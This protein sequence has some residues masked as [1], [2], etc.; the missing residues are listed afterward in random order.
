MS[1]T[2]PL[3]MVRGRITVQEAGTAQYR[4]L[5]H[6]TGCIVRWVA[7]WGWVP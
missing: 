6:A 2:Y 4:G 1:A 7:A 3:D 5:L